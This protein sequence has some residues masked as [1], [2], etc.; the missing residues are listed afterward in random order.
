MKKFNLFFMALVSLMSLIAVSGFSAPAAAG[1]P[2]VIVTIEGSSFSPE[3]VT[4][5]VGGEV[6]WKNKDAAAHTV[7]ADNGSFDSGALGQGD[8]FKQKFPTAGTIT[9]SCDNHAWMKGK[10]EVR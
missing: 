5:K 8:E 1:D 9:Y 4:I 2:P 7:T 3:V 10:I 6:V